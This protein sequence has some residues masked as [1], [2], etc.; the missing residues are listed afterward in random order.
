MAQ[1][2][3][4]FLNRNND[5]PLLCGN[6]RESRLPFTISLRGVRVEWR[7]AGT[8]RERRRLHEADQ[9][10]RHETTMKP[11]RNAGCRK[12]IHKLSTDCKTGYETIRTATL[13]TNQA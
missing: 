12:R 9:R 4:N 8:A 2:L 5:R 10:R 11:V 6:A 1:A 7:V 3:L 13:R